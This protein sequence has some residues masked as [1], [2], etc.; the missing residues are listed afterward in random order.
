[1]QCAF[2]SIYWLQLLDDICALNESLKCFS[3][4]N[5]LKIF[6][7]GAEDFS[8]QMNSEIL[9]CTIKFT[10]F[11]D[12]LF[13]N[14]VALYF[15]LS[16]C[17]CLSVC[18]SRVCL[19]LCLSLSLSLSLSVSLCLSL[20]L[21]SLSLTKKLV[22]NIFYMYFMFNLCTEFTVTGICLT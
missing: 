6:L 18:L 11:N 4:E 15:F 14:L 19:C 21:L 13:I 3:N 5:L 8:T 22:F 16:C 12:P 2:Y 10:K 7:Y 20:S 9:K 1:M 17:F